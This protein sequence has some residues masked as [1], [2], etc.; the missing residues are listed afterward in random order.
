MMSRMCSRRTALLALLA[1]PL[2][3]W[4]AFAVE[5][6][7]LTIPLDQWKGLTITHKGKK[8]HLRAEDVFA[9]L[10]EEEQS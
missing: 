5:A 3:S 10:S 7:W 8:I 4:R 1:I 6:G 9:A 2:G